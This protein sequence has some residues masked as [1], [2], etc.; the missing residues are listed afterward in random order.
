M[1]SAWPLAAAAAPVVGGSGTP[2]SYTEQGAPVPIGQNV[3]I[4]SDSGSPSTYGGGYIDFQINGDPASALLS[5]QSDASPSTVDGA[6]S[7]VDGIAYRGNGTTADIIGSVDE[8]LDGTNGHLRVNFTSPFSNSSFEDGITGWTPV[9]QQVDLGVT[10]I[11]GYPSLETGTY[12]SGSVA[13]PQG[14]PT[15]QDNNVPSRLGTLAVKRDTTQF[16]DGKA[17]L[18]LSSVGMTTLAGCDV[19]HGPAVYSD[20]FPASKGD[21]IYFD[22]RAFHGDDAYD[23]LGYILNSD[24]G[25][26]TPVLDATGVGTGD[27]AWATVNASIPADGDYRFVFVAG[28]FD[29]TCGKAAGASLFIDNVRVYGKKATDAAAQ[30]IAHRLLY[31]NTSTNPPTTPQTLTVTVKDTTGTTATDTQPG[32]Q[33]QPVDDPPTLASPTAVA[34]TNTA[35]APETFAVQ[36]GTLTGTDP[37]STGLVYGIAGGVANSAV[38]GFDT[39][40]AGAF[41][42]LYLNSA[43]GAYRF[44]PDAT[45]IDSTMVSAADAFTLTVTADG[46]SDAKQ[47]AV[48][49]TVP[50]SGVAH[51]PTGLQAEPGAASAVLTWTAPDWTGGT[52]LTGYRI[53]WSLDGGLTW[54]SADTGSTDTAYTVTG[55]ANGVDTR[56]RVSAITGAGAGAASSPSSAT[57]RTA[58]GAPTGLAAQPG[59]TQVALSWQAPADD[60]GAPVTGYRI[61]MLAT[62]GWTTLVADTASTATTYTATGLTNGTRS[63]FRVTAINVGGASVA[64]DVA[65]ATPRTVPGAP[66]GLAVQ[67]GDGQAV[68]SW[69]APSDDGGAP[70]TGY[71]IEMSSDGT[72]WTGVVADTGST[73]TTFTV[74]SLVNG[75]ATQFRVSAVNVAGAGAPGAVVSTT[76]R[77]VPGLPTGLTAAPGDHQVV[78]AWTAPAADGGAP[79]SGYRIEKSTDGGKTWTVQVADTGSTATGYIADDVVNGTETAFRVSAIN[80]AGVGA[81]GDPAST[82]PR[83]TAT[84]LAIT[85][86]T[87]GNHTLTV[88]FTPPSDD[89]GAPVTGY[90]YSLDGGTTWVPFDASVSPLVIG[91]LDNGVDYAFTMR[92][93]NAAGPGPSTAVRSVRAE[94]SPVAVPGSTGTALPELNPGETRMYIDGKEVTVTV[95]RADGVLTFQ[96]DGYTIRISA[97]DKGAVQLDAQGRIV[98]THGGTVHVSGTGFKPGSTADVWLFSA[99]VLLGQPVVDGTG[100]F[101]ASYQIPASTPAGAHTLQINGLSADGKLRTA[102]TGVILEAET[103]LASTGSS[104]AGAMVAGGFAVALVLAG[105]LLGARNRRRRTA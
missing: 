64:S 16:T 89:G 71:G 102:V 85:S 39:A 76:P 103:G 29:F 60:G 13:A 75:T 80:A 8:K 62:G 49:I 92:A 52:A 61:E 65:V 69:T 45:A 23:V 70:V 34:Y 67:P 59:D 25:A 82:T 1:A 18:S 19:V 100:D 57:P 73:A 86:I 36:N 15:N 37:D 22:W 87:P 63:S 96:G 72:T 58:P 11:A 27:T 33:I 97:D 88:A 53:E 7:I 40:R 26:T 93:V 79:I 104:A 14:P 56:F 101:A 38:A 24:T 48:D 83:T 20:P 4:T 21:Q 90:E 30:E 74:G 91:G 17:S 81:P 46:K 6:I 51:A 105:A 98:I 99:P 3:T 68:L 44:V 84:G 66:T 9:T 35:A 55:L 10:P 78:L 41:G 54:T 43:T 77:T 31:K 12:P 28:T 5:L 47:L 42:T 94:V 32:V 95:T 50:V 2:I